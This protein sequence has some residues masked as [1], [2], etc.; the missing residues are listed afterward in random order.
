MPQGFI[1]MATGAH[2]AETLQ[3][4]C[5]ELGCWLLESQRPKSIDE[6]KESLGPQTCRQA[7]HAKMEVPVFESRGQGQGCMS[8]WHGPDTNRCL[9]QFCLQIVVPG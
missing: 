4:E 7:Q 9:C 5:V 1:F 2:C 6:G 3:K 8:A